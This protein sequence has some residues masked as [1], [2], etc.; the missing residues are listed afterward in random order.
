MKTLYV[1]RHAKSSWAEPNQPDIDRKLNDRGVENA[2]MMAKRLHER[3]ATIDYKICSPAV[4][5]TQTAQF[6]CAEFG[7]NLS[8][9]NFEK[10]I[11]EAPLANLLKVIS[12]I[13]NQCNSAVL[14]GHNFGVSLLVN[15]LT[16][17]YVQMPTCA[18]VTIEL[19]IDQWEML[20]EGIGRL[21]DYDYPKKNL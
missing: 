21:M 1:I 3:V 17:D 6:F 8:E 4:R 9:L 13:P 19:N 12:S 11:Y 5:T 7:W 14:F 10:S 2:P 20:S 18:I 15:H 16:D